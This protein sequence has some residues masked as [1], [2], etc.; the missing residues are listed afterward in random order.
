MCC[1]SNVRFTQGLKKPNYNM[2][3]YLEIP[4]QKDIMTGKE[5]FRIINR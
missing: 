2:E 5:D 3:M 4:S 1:Q